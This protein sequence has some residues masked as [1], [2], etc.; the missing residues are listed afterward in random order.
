MT[1][2]EARQRAL[3]RT[4]WLLAG[5]WARPGDRQPIV[6]ESA[7]PAHRPAARPNAILLG[8]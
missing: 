8:G 2:V 6:P 1:N 7:A 4:E 3:Q 5:N